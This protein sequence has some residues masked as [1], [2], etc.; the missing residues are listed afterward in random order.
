MTELSDIVEAFELLGDWDERYQYLME[1]GSQL[2]AMPAALKTEDNR[3]KPCMSTVHVCAY[4]SPG[5]PNRIRFYGDCDTDIIKGV[6]AVLISLCN[7]KRVDEVLA[8]DMDRVFEQL[9]L[10]E[11]L[12]P[13]RHVGVYAIVEV[14]KQQVLQ[15]GSARDAVA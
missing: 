7:D 13:S 9:R 15:L 10:H 5:S 11:H 12:S 4:R 14:M 1:L 6:L 8:I 2:P 3:V